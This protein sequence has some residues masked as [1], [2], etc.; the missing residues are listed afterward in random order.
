M[1]NFD[2]SENVY[3]EVRTYFE[4]YQPEQGA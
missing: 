2:V 1:I 4:K 3:K